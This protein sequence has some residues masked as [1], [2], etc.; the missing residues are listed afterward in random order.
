MLLM[1]VKTRAY[2]AGLPGV[3]IAELIGAAC[4]QNAKAYWS[5]WGPL[6]KPMIRGI[7]AWEDMQRGYLQSLSGA[8]RVVKST[9]EAERSFTKLEAAVEAPVAFDESEHPK[10]AEGQFSK[11]AEAQED[12]AIEDYDS[13]NV[14]QAAQRLEE[15][16]DAEIEQIRHYEGANKNRSTLLSRVDERLEA[17]I[18]SGHPRGAEGQFAEVPSIEDYDSL[19]VQEVREQLGGMNVEE[20][21][22]LRA[23][24]AEHK[25]RQTLL[26]HVDAVIDAAFDASSN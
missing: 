24:E 5:W 9:E 17:S 23:Y 13:L 20:I 1:Q 21:K 25:N 16:G 6:G 26:A 18:N 14:K 11:V 19:N 3:R 10:D 8:P 2:E 4:A 7:E 12:L 15:L 22:E